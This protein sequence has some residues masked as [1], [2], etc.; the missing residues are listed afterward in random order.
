[1]QPLGTVRCRYPDSSSDTCCIQKASDMSVE[2]SW[3]R[4]LSVGLGHSRINDNSDSVPT[5]CRRERPFPTRSPVC[6]LLFSPHERTR[7][8]HEEVT[9]T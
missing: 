8:A 5:T 9:T 7:H 4:Q 3:R 6:G 1:M 2:C